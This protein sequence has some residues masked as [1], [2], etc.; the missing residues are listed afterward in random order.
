[1]KL[2]KR[3]D[4][5]CRF[6]SDVDGSARSSIPGGPGGREL[7][8]SFSE[9]GGGRDVEYHAAWSLGLMLHRRHIEVE[10]REP[11]L[12]SNCSRA[13]RLR[14]DCPPKCFGI[15]RDNTC[16]A[17]RADIRLPLRISTANVT[18]L[19][20]TSLMIW[21]TRSL[22]ALRLKKI[23]P[24]CTSSRLDPWRH[25]GGLA[26]PAIIRLIISLIDIVQI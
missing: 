3:A 26:L 6:D 24:P 11:D 14:T 9:D 16:I 12:I 23:M 4:T 10:T 13:G 19:G 1:M 22:S 17:V 15:V 18:L 25:R 5:G 20:Q 7:L 8:I 21:N 2:L